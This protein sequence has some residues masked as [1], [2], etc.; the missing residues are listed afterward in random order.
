MAIPPPAPPP[1]PPPPP[2]G[3]GKA[4][5][6]SSAEKAALT[7]ASHLRFFINDP[8]LDSVASEGELREAIQAHIKELIETK[9]LANA[10]VDFFDSA[11]PANLHPEMYL[12]MA[13]IQMQLL[14]RSDKKRAA[15]VLL[16]LIAPINV[17][18]EKLTEHV[19]HQVCALYEKAFL[20]LEVRP[21]SAEEMNKLKINTLKDPRA[22]SDYHMWFRVSQREAV[23]N[24]ESV[25]KKRKFYEELLVQI[26]TLENPPVAEE[27]QE[28]SDPQKE[29]ERQFQ[30]QRLY[31][32][33]LDY[34]PNKFILN[35]E[36]EYRATEEKIAVLLPTFD[37]SEIEGNT[38]LKTLQERL[39]FLQKQ[40]QYAQ[41]HQIF[42]QSDEAKMLESLQVYLLART[43]KLEKISD[44][45]DEKR[46]QLDLNRMGVDKLQV[47]IQALE[48]TCL[49]FEEDLDRYCAT[50]PKCKEQL[51]AY[52]ELRLEKKSTVEKKTTVSESI[53]KLRL[54]IQNLQESERRSPREETELT[55]AQA[56]LLTKEKSLEAIVEAGSRIDREC[57]ALAKISTGAPGNK[58]HYVKMAVVSHLG[59]TKYRHE[60]DKLRDQL[61]R[62][63]SKRDLLECELEFARLQ[64]PFATI[65]H[66]KNRKFL[67]VVR[68]RKLFL[69]GLKTKKAKP[70][71]LD[72]K[73]EAVE[74]FEEDLKDKKSLYCDVMAAKPGTV[75]PPFTENELEILEEEIMEVDKLVEFRAGE[76]RHKALGMLL[77]TTLQHQGRTDLGFRE[78]PREHINE[79]LNHDFMQVREERLLEFK[80]LQEAELYQCIPSTEVQS[81]PYT[82]EE[83]AKL[84]VK[85]G[86]STDKELQTLLVTCF[87]ELRGYLKIPQTH[88]SATTALGFTPRA[89]IH[90]ILGYDIMAK[91]QERL[92][93]AK[94]AALGQSRRSS[95]SSG[96][97]SSHATG[98]ASGGVSSELADRLRER[99]KVVEHQLATEERKLNAERARA[100]KAEDEALIAERR[101]QEA[102]EKLAALKNKPTGSAA[103]LTA[104]E[105]RAASALKKNRR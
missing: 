77:G 35:R 41:L 85:L 47:Q 70:E 53:K 12:A 38:K 60:I 101:R 81:S 51:A 98:N 96:S 92:E 69:Q 18:P 1:P 22:L 95:S 68:A 103:P 104:A 43:K 99:L 65:M 86:A 28:E 46:N 29:A 16:E 33:L 66:E 74:K 17:D 82:K 83:I 93:A 62:A 36:M 44:E 20:A 34:H 89:T 32:A 55:Q 24:L 91:H 52:L 84:K 94:N 31:A 2:P 50:D 64:Q 40:I 78:Y 105:R 30:L 3:G 8:T 100:R 72:K 56:D 5:G 54:H 59:L 15:Q 39:V 87:D 25:A 73:K 61:R 90:S 4:G 97:S 49:T 63:E 48:R 37:K 45:T 27:Q 76:E 11:P 102:E 6:P 10:K 88:K 75:F 21:P 26:D 58:T 67:K 13:E 80:L 23:K 42:D 9:K 19:Q 71:P 7:L 14:K 79:I 57:C